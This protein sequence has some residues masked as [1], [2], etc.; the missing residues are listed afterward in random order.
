[1]KFSAGYELAMSQLAIAAELIYSTK[2][3]SRTKPR[4]ARQSHITNTHKKFA[5]LTFLYGALVYTF[6]V[7]AVL[8]VIARR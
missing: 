1:M 8:V 5:N 7:L 6:S 2:L 4:N 3:V